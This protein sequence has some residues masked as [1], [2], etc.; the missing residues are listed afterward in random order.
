M[1]NMFFKNDKFFL[2]KE[3]I[4]NQ[5]KQLS[6]MEIDMF[7]TWHNELNNYISSN[8]VEYLSINEEIYVKIDKMIQHVCPMLNTHYYEVDD[9]CYVKGLVVKP[10]ENYIDN[11]FAPEQRITVETRIRK[12]N[13]DEFTQVLN[14]T[15]KKLFHYKNDNFEIQFQQFPGIFIYHV[16]KDYKDFFDDD[17]IDF[18]NNIEAKWNSMFG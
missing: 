8:E 7:R 17:V 3:Y 10:Q 9:T 18:T 12:I 13:A 2:L 4:D 1:D 15:C 5:R 14:K 6:D 16:I 11:A